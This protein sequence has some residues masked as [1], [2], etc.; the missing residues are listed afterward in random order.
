MNFVDGASGQGRLELRIGRSEPSSLVREYEA[1]LVAHWDTIAGLIGRQQPSGAGVVSDLAS[2]YA[3]VASA[4]DRDREG[5]GA[6]QARALEAER[7]RQAWAERATEAERQ[8]ESW[9]G[10]ALQ[11]EGQRMEIERQREAWQDR[12]LEAEGQRETW[13]ARAI[14]AEGQCQA[15]EARIAD[16]ERELGTAKGTIHVMETSRS[17]RLTRPLRIARRLGR[18]E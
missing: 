15:S 13:Q 7:K 18:A 12:A 14:D 10:R 4:L 11:A 5:L 16:I 17:W 1:Q 6:E 2:S 3:R 8:R 9:Q